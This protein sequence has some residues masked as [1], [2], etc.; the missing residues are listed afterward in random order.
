MKNTLKIDYS[1]RNFSIVEKEK[2]FAYGECRK[3]FNETVRFP[4]VG[5]T[6]CKIK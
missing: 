5:F 2:K 1:G 6:K 4:N 3:N